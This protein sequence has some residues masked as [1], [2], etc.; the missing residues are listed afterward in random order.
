MDAV[1]RAKL[2]LGVKTDLALSQA[3]GLS[4]AVVGGYKRRDSIP[5]EQCIKIAERTGVS[6]DWLILGKGDKESG[7]VTQRAW[8]LL[9]SQRDNTPMDANAYLDCVRKR[10]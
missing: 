8:A 9:E 3:L 6:L 7:N 10:T 2:A 1:E 5:L 4:A